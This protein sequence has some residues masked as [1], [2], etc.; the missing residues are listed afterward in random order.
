MYTNLIWQNY[1]FVGLP[2]ARV[3]WRLFYKKKIVEDRNI[4]GM[5]HQGLYY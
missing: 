1:G 4:L 5:G 2:G 3:L